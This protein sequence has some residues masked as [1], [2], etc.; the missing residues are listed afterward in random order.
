MVGA[1]FNLCYSAV[2]FKCELICNL[3]IELYVLSMDVVAQ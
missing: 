3:N 1:D 2:N